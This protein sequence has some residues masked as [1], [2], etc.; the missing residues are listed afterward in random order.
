M[1]IREEPS[2]LSPIICIYDDDH[3]EHDA[4]ETSG[5]PARREKGQNYS[6]A[7]DNKKTS[8]P[9]KKNKKTSGFLYI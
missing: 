6:F 5:N 4:G 3:E 8:V 1:C 7:I 2:T 9:A